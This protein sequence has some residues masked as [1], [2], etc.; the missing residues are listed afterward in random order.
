MIIILYKMNIIYVDTRYIKN[1][2]GKFSILYTFLYM[3]IS[4]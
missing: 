3:L 4:L 2:N 1:N